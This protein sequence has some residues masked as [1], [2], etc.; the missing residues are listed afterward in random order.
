MSN[1]H[2]STKGI[3][4]KESRFVLRKF[5]GPIFADGIVSQTYHQAASCE[6]EAFVSF[7][8]SQQYKR[9]ITVAFNIIEIDIENKMANQ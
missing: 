8:K 2:D 7:Q 1:N 9:N 4:I 5:D 6:N 3:T